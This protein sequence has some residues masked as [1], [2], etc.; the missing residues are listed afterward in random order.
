MVVV[1]VNL[2]YTYTKNRLNVSFKL[3]SLVVFELHLNK[4]TY[5]N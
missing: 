5:E 1:V 2:D 3:V 4:D